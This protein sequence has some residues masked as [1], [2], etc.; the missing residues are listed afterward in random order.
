[1]SRAPRVSP[2]AVALAGLLVVLAAVALIDHDASS[3]AGRDR[4]AAQRQLVRS[5]RAGCERGKL[6]RAAIAAALRAQSTYLQL[7]LDARSVKADVKRAAAAN[8]SVQDKSASSLE[9]RTGTRLNCARAF[10]SSAGPSGPSPTKPP[11]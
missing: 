11:E 6:D 9:S 5:Q 1:V 7:V 3:R 2:T 4:R 8:Q 10:P